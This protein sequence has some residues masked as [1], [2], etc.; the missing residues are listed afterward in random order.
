V[1]LGPVATADGRRSSC[2][3]WGHSLRD[4]HMSSRI[5]PTGS[6]DPAIRSIGSTQ[7][8][9]TMWSRWQKGGTSE[10]PNL[11][12]ACYQCNDMKRAATLEELRWS[13]FDPAVSAWQGLSEY[14]W[15]L[16]SALGWSATSIIV[17]GLAQRA[18]DSGR[19][20]GG[21]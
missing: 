21:L 4:S 17:N 16:C 11:V 8:A 1:T 3:C 19:K 9:L 20:R 14:Y 10:V 7:P 6:S 2:R 12:T 18:F 13:L 15:A 5:I